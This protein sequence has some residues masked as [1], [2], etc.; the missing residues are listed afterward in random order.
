MA[1]S[2]PEGE[3]FF[4]RSALKSDAYDANNLQDFYAY[5]LVEYIWNQE[6]YHGSRL[7][8]SPQGRW[9]PRSGYKIVNG[10]LWNTDYGCWENLPFSYGPEPNDIR[11]R[12]QHDLCTSGNRFKDRENGA[13]AEVNS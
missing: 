9:H 12:G 10:H 7:A 5:M 3:C 4:E 13:S 2:Y 8:N 11:R 1:L 6:S